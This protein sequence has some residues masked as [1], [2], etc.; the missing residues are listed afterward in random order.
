MHHI[1]NNPAL[2]LVVTFITSHLFVISNSIN[3]DPS[4]VNQELAQF[5]ALDKF[6]TQIINEMEIVIKIMKLDHSM[7]LAVS[8]TSSQLKKY[9]FEHFH[10][11][12]LLILTD[13]IVLY[14]FRLT[15]LKAHLIKGKNFYK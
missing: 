1:S 12:L 2:T 4:C 13:F 14:K 3:A 6:S 7:H 11:K 10:I 15:N 9:S 8:K 5:E